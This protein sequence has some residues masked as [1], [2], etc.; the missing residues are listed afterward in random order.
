MAYCF[1]RNYGQK[2]SEVRF[3][4]YRT[5]PDGIVKIDPETQ[6]SI[7]NEPINSKTSSN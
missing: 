2:T 7:L 4:V 5:N 3:A 1:G 6:I